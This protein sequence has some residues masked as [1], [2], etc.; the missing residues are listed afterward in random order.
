MSD[1]IEEMLA[2]GSLIEAGV[3]ESGEQLYIYTDLCRVL[4]PK[5]WKAKYQEFLDDISELWSLGYI[6]IELGENADLDSIIIN[7][8]TFGPAD[9]LPDRLKPALEAVRASAEEDYGFKKDD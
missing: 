9:D 2:D 8:K 4:H 7:E 5:V 6:E 3:S 1:D